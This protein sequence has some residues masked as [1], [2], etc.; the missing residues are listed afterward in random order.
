[1]ISTRLNQARH[2]GITLLGEPHGWTHR[3]GEHR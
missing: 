2:D 3:G 1:M